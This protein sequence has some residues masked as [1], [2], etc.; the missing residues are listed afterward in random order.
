MASL[1]Q[2]PPTRDVCVPSSKAPWIYCTSPT[3]PLPRNPHDPQT[4]FSTL[5]EAGSRPPPT[6]R[7][8]ILPNGLPTVTYPT[9]LRPKDI[10]PTSPVEKKE[11]HFTTR[12][13][14]FS[15]PIAIPSYSSNFTNRTAFSRDASRT[16][17]IHRK[18]STANRRIQLKKLN[19]L[20][21]WAT[22]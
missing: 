17:A 2:L 9:A 7:S 4:V 22:R 19:T 18:N 12:T 3:L 15:R 14:F 20:R 13:H 1:A 10:Q 6:Q 16:I 5:H 21:P 11:N 8:N